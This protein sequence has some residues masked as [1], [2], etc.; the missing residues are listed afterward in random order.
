MNLIMYVLC[1]LANEFPCI[2]IKTINTTANEVNASPSVVSI[3]SAKQDMPFCCN[4]F[5][6]ANTFTFLELV[7]LITVLVVQFINELNMIIVTIAVIQM[8]L[9]IW[10]LFA[11]IQKEDISLIVLT[12]I[13]AIWIAAFMMLL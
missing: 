9:T 3:L 2:Q 6:I 13:R 5:V 1:I 4:C 12:S 7:L 8:I 11:V 10:E